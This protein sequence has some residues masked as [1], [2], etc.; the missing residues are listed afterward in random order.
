MKK[1]S[2]LTFVC[3]CLFVLTPAL[4][5][6]AA[7]TADVLTSLQAARSKLVELIGTTDKGTQS[8]L[9][10]DIKK[11]TQ[12]VDKKVS[13]VEGDAATTPEVKAKLVE[14]KATWAEFQKTRDGEIIPAVT[15]GDA[16]KAKSLA[17]GV[18]VERFKKMTGLL[19]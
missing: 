13:E 1:M 18:Q 10:E 9:I 6:A 16:A 4:A 12:E 19:Q 2:S 15:A 8:V 17:Q 7:T 11:A 14:F 5:G 3:M